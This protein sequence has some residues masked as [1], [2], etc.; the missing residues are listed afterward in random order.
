MVTCVVTAGILLYAFVTAIMQQLRYRA[1]HHNEV[2]SEILAGENERRWLA[3]D[4]HDD[5]GPLLSATK[6]NLSAIDGKDQSDN[7][8]MNESIQYIDE[9]SDKIRSLARGLMPNVLLDKGLAKAV[10][11][12]I[13]NMGNAGNVDIQLKVETIPQLHVNAS[14]HLYRII[15]EII[16]NCLKHAHANR[17]IIK[18]YTR[19]NNLVL[20]AS[21]DGIGF[22]L[23]NS[24]KQHSGYGLTGIRNRVHLLN[25]SF[26]LRSQPGTSY[27]IEIPVSNL[28]DT[29]KPG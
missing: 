27:F 14:I 23:K 9:I 13:N 29:E 21:D 11:Q 1:Q 8:L 19:N 28:S 6:M 16:H 5:L 15:Q 25:G 20:A 18:I 7:T 24:F 3:A 2:E 17:L 12:F 10:Q 4:M 22:K 26:N